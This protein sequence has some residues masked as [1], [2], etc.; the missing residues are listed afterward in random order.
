MR[1]VIFAAAADPLLAVREQPLIHHALSTLQLAGIR[2]VL[3]VATPA[4]TARLQHHLGGGARWGVQLSYLLQPASGG[5]V[6]ALALASEFIGD[7]RC[8][9]IRA[10]HIFYGDG[11][12]DDLRAAATLKKGARLVVQRVDNPGEHALVRFDDNGIASELT[13]PADTATATAAPPHYAVTG[14]AFYDHTATARARELLSSHEQP[15]ITALNQTY[16]A[17]KKLQVTLCARATTWLT[18]DANGR[19]AP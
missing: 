11:L 1:G 14:L 9:L 15:S 5:V 10:D 7:H 12:A 18:L 13:E 2:S 4:D 19:G 17:E 6:E 8:A 3:V 16:L